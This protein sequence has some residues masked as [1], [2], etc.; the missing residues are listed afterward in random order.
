MVSTRGKRSTL[1]RFQVESWDL[2]PGA[3]AILVVVGKYIY[4]PTT[5]K[6]AVAPGSRSQDSTWNRFKV[7]RFPLVETMAKSCF[8]PQT[9]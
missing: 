3:T 2:L 6:I 4:F 5:T 9:F 8:W 1:N 7:E